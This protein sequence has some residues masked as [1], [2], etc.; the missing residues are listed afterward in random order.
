M[1][2]LIICLLSFAPPV[3]SQKLPVVAVDHPFLKILIEKLVDT[4]TA[5][6]RFP[7]KKIRDPH[8]FRPG[9]ATINQFLTAN[10]IVAGPDSI[11][12]W[13]REILKRKKQTS[14]Q[15]KSTGDT[16]K[17]HY[18]LYPQQIC[19]ISSQLARQLKSWDLNVKTM[20]CNFKGLN[21]EFELLKSKFSGKTF[22]ISHNSLADLL[23][24]Y[25]F[26]TLVVRQADHHHHFSV[27]QVK[28]LIQS[29]KKIK[30]GIYISEKNV[31]LPGKIK[32]V[33]SAKKFLTL[34]L[35][36]YHPKSNEIF[37]YLKSLLKGLK[38]L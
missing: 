14:F 5:I 32:Q 7:I 27:V 24:S 34:N 11:S 1:K 38:Q 18:W 2:M 37:T 13:M 10:Y 20:G 25:G 29:L 15:I 35:D 26:K 6:V 36:T 4:K 19:Q 8:H 17:D 23:N 3:F 9:R 33:V 31:I 28:K 12:P 16:A 22:V 30:N 21:K